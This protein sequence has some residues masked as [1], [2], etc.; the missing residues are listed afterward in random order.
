ML[1]THSLYIWNCGWFAKLGN[2]APRQEL[3]LLL[4]LL[5]ALVQYE[6]RMLLN[7]TLP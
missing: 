7:L 3:M 2:V 5:Q 1:C 4:L 6:Y